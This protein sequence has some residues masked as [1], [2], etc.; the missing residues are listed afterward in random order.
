MVKSAF[1]WM[2]IELCTQLL[3]QLH[4][5][6]SLNWGIPWIKR[7]TTQNLLTTRTSK[8]YSCKVFISFTV[9]E[10]VFLYQSY[11]PPPKVLIFIYL[12]MSL[13]VCIYMN[14]SIC[15]ISILLSIYLSTCATRLMT[16]KN[17]SS[18]DVLKIQWFLYA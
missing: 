6:D 9:S 1:N 4:N 5:I 2:G 14:I 11:P 8:E 15:I 16:G 12:S 13:Y 10:S 3:Y 7:R 17:Q 18:G